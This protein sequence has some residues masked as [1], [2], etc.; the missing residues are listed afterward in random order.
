MV[1]ASVKVTVLPVPG[2][3]ITTITVGP[4]I[5]RGRRRSHPGRIRARPSRSTRAR[6]CRRV[7]SAGR[8]KGTLPPAPGRVGRWLLRRVTWLALGQAGSARPDAPSAC[9]AVAL[10]T[11]HAVAAIGDPREDEQRHQ[12]L[13]AARAKR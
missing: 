4:A 10:L 12:A 3:V 1:G 5:D 13:E 9:S 8:S 11:E 6:P 2:P 7:L